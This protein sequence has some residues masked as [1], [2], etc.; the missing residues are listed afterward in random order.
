MEE[1][2]FFY[3]VELERSH[4][5]GRNEKLTFTIKANP[6]NSILTRWN[7]ASVAAGKTPNPVGRH[8]SVKLPFFRLCRKYIF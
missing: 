1:R 6:T 7:S 4:V 3:G 5:S 8:S 2:F